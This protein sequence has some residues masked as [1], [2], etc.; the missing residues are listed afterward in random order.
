MHLCLRELAVM[1]KGPLFKSIR[2]LVVLP[3]AILLAAGLVILRRK[4][5]RQVPT[6]YLV[7]R[8]VRYL[9]CPD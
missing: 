7:V 3:A 5:A 1:K 4:A 8:D 6:L 2:V 9:L